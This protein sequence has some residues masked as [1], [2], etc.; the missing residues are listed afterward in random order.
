MNRTVLR[1]VAAP[2]I[3]ALALGL[4]VSACGAGNETGGSTSSDLSGTLKG[5]GSSAQESAMDA[6][7]AGFQ[8]DNPDVTVNYDP[9][10]SGAGVE[11]F[12]AGA[13]DYA[14]SDSAL[15]PEKGEDAAAKERCGADALQVPNYISPIALVYNLDGVDKLQLSAKTVAGIFDGTIKKWNDPAIAAENAGVTLPADAIAP[16]HR[17]DESGTTKNFTDY[18]EKASDGAWKFPADKVWPIKS[19]EAANGTSGVIAAVKAG[20]GSIGYAD[21]SQ[22]GDLSQASIKVGDAYVA[23]S[24]EGAA[25]ALEASPIDDSRPEGSLVIK[26]DRATTEAGAYPLM[27]TSYVFACPTYDKA[28]ADLVKGFLSY[29]VS[30]KGQEEAAKNAGSA[31]LPAS[32]QEKAAAIIDTISAK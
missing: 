4:A 16:V 29:V 22:A 28:K 20:K 13:I 21:E 19:G 3:A 12:N 9:A 26:V 15:D 10:G 14:G 25:K 23:P 11:Q 7:R 18:L 5:A 2:S 24:A 6:W 27:L 1:R 31:P 32:L 8:T 30:T 17:S